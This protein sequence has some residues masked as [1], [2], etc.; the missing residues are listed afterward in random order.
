MAVL[1]LQLWYRNSEMTD[2][3]LSDCIFFAFVVLQNVAW[4]FQLNM[5]IEFSILVGNHLAIML[6]TFLVWN[7]VDCSEIIYQKFKRTKRWYNEIK[8]KIYEKWN[9]VEI[10]LSYARYDRAW[11]IFRRLRFRISVENQAWEDL[12]G[13][14]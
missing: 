14:E 13:K 10:V 4:V 11:G 12:K 2:S 1:F 7:H 8:T 6:W 9:T 3:P 5:K